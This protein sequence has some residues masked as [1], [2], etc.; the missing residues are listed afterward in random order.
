MLTWF[1]RD[2]TNMRRFFNLSSPLCRHV[3]DGIPT[4]VLLP[5]TTTRL[6]QSKAY[7][8]LVRRGVEG[9]RKVQSHRI[10]NFK[11]SPK[12][13]SSNNVLY[14]KKKLFLLAL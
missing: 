8:C 4:I 1:N 10:S 9:E 7:T 5:H 14:L 11:G 13:L 6:E 3:D 12:F 2:R